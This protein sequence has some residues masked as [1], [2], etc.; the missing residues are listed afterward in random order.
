MRWPFSRPDKVD[1]V[2]ESRELKVVVGRL[3]KVEST[4]DSIVADDEEIRVRLEVIERSLPV[5][6]KEV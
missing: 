4:L 1:E 2:R 6:V 5:L 3:E